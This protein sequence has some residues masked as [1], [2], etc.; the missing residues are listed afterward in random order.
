[1]WLLSA[2]SVRFWKQTAICPVSL[3][4]LVVELHPLNWARPQAVRRI[5]DKV[6]IKELEEQRV[7]GWNFAANF[8]KILQRHFNCLTKH[9]VWSV[10]SDNYS[11]CCLPGRN[12][13][14]IRYEASGTLKKE[15]VRSSEMYINLYQTI[16]LQLSLLK[17]ALIN[18]LFF[19]YF[20][21]AAVQKYLYSRAT[22]PSNITVL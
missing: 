3:W 15:Y 19:L 16:R 11:H 1:M 12:A 4:A 17:I 6:T 21:R 22:V 10:H 7:C 2:P 18:M 8:V 5:S 9:E 13:T 14:D 20:H